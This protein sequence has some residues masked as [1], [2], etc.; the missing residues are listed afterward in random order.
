[1][2]D[3]IGEKAALAGNAAERRSICA[4][5]QRAAARGAAGACGAE[6]SSLVRDLAIPDGD[7]DEATGHG[8]RRPTCT[9]SPHPGRWHQEWHDGE[10]RA[11]WSGDARWTP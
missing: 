6:D 3:W 7:V 10:L 4:G 5:K 9:L 8:W 11:E 1:V 2:A